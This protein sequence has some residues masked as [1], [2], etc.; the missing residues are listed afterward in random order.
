MDEKTGTIGFTVCAV[1]FVALWVGYLA[2]PRLYAVAAAL[3][4]LR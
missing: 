2:L 1:L 4:A 3:E